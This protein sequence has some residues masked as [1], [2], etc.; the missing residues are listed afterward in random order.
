MNVLAALALIGSLARAAAAPLDAGTTVPAQALGAGTTAPASVADAATLAQNAKT[1][2]DAG[3]LKTALADAEAAVAAGGGAEAFAR[4]AEA[5]LALG[6]PLDEALSD[7]A[8][9]ARLDPRYE[10]KY[11]GI[12]DQFQSE[13]RRGKP[14]DARNEG[15]GGVSMLFVL[16]LAAAGLVLLVCGFLF[17]HLKKSAGKS[18]S[19]L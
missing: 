8:E 9:A 1:L 15:A 16:G 6:R 14:K 10:E 13:S 12:L 2:L 7:Y 5:K 19:E 3:D 18:A 11:R 17:L 4:R